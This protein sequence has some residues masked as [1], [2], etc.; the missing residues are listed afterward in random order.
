VHLIVHLKNTFLQEFLC[1][2]LT[3]FP[4]RSQ[5]FIEGTKRDGELDSHP[6]QEIIEPETNLSYTG[7][8]QTHTHTHTDLESLS[9]FCRVF[10]NPQGRWS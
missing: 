10:Q 2:S 6:L 3:E 7:K 4:K 1:D 5:A 9:D 8:T